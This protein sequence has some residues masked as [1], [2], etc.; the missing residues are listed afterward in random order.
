M[1]AEQVVEER[2]KIDITRHEE[3][4]TELAK[5]H[6]LLVVINERQQTVLNRLDKI[7]G[8]VA[9]YNANKQ[10]FDTAC[11][12]VTTLEVEVVRAREVLTEKVVANEALI[13]QAKIQHE[14]ELQ[15]LDNRYIGKRLFVTLSVILGVLITALGI[16]NI[17]EGYF[18]R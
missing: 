1:T 7:N 5:N 16:F 13:L 12:K 9:D 18:I 8:T 17:M 10:K 3:T 4:I 11:Q 6:D 2:R 15:E 14:K